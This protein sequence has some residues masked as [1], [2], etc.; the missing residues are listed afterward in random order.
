MIVVHH[1]VMVVMHHHVMMIVMHD[2]DFISH[3]C[4][5]R[6][7]DGTGQNGRSDNF[8]QHRVPL[9]SESRGR[10]AMIP[11]SYPDRDLNGG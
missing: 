6:E 9:F 5:R 7:G 3:G 11:S 2:H 10:A 4:D 8:L 1:H